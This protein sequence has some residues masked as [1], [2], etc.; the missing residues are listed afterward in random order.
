M[1]EDTENVQMKKGMR[2]WVQKFHHV[3][4]VAMYWLLVSL[5]LEKQDYLLTLIRNVV[6]RELGNSDILEEPQQSMEKRANYNQHM[7][8]DPSTFSDKTRHEWE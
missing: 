2:R 6:G 3:G 1:G 4:R 8:K 5:R 7:P